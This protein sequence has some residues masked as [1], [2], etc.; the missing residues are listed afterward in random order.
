MN[1]NKKFGI[2]AIEY[3][4]PKN[5]TSSDELSE[6]FSY[7]KDFIEN[8]IG[9]KQ[10][11]SVGNS[12]SLDMSVKVL[13]KILERFPFLHES[14]DVLVV[15]SQTPDHQLPQISSQIQDICRINKSVMAFDISLGCSGFVYG[16]SIVQSLLDF[17]N[18]SNGL[19]ITSETYS[20]II[21]ENDRNTRCLFSD[22]SAATLISNKGQIFSEKYKFSSEGKLFD[23]LICCKDKTNG[24][25]FMDGRSI[26]NFVSSSVVSEIKSCILEN[27]LRI[28][29]I[30][31]FILHQA[32][33]FVL[34]SVAQNL[35]INYEKKFIDYIKIFGNTVSSS[36]P[37]AM[38]Q[39]FQNNTNKEMKILISGFGVGL[40]SGSTILFSQK[41]ISL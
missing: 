17:H 37:I 36:I 14:L 41:N 23:K 7:D 15:C 8:K 30:D 21:D 28:E 26:F 13:E 22:A 6:K 39:F 40:S 3:Y 9:V 2:Q 35:G 19:L 27:G 4:L 38:K 10:L 5:V 12:S 16:L 24:N 32:S 31:Y 29:D 1:L 20:K 18:L 11:F 34:K 25:L 33:S